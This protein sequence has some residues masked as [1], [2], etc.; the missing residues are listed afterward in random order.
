[1]N[2]PALVTAACLAASGL[3]AV[4][5]GGSAAVEP[6]A[7]A[8]NAVDWGRCGDPVLRQLGGER[9][10]VSVPLDYSHPR[11]TKIRL[12]VSRVLHT[13]PDSQDQGVMLV[14][15]GGPGGSGLIY[16]ILG[17][18]IPSGAGDAYDW[19]GFDP[20]GVGSSQP[21]L[22]CDGTFFN[23]PRPPYEPTTETILNQ[24][25]SKSKAYARACTHADGQDRKSVV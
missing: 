15:P 11:G 12:A 19:I 5:P 14:N 17:A 25:V 2:L 18:F 22:A 24:W 23:G 7:G 20:R 3:I 1:M 21:S 4:A 6:T 13:T 10:F 16:S 8:A 9:G